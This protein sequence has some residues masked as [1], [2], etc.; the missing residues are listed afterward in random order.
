MLPVKIYNEYIKAYNNPKIIHY[1]DRI[2]PWN[3]PYYQNANIWWK[4]ARMVDSYEEIVYHNIWNRNHNNYN[5]YY[6]TDN[7]ISIADFILSFVNNENE[8]SIMFLGIKIRIKK[9]FLQENYIYYNKK[10]RIFSIYSND[11][12]TRLTILGIKITIKKR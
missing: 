1:C 4:Y 11:R 5:N 2:K 6:Y 3:S 10:D 12:Y 9:N 8:L 7:R